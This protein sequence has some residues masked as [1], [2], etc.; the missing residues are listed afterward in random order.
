MRLLDVIKN[1]LAITQ[2]SRIR[3][4]PG[5][6]KTAV[7]IHY[8]GGKKSAIA[9]G[10]TGDPLA[11]RGLRDVNT[12]EP[13]VTLNEWSATPDQ[14][15]LCDSDGLKSQIDDLAKSKILGCLNTESLGRGWVITTHAG[16]QTERDNW[17]RANT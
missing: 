7:I 14:E 15:L 12:P 9:D 4:L 3:L 1:D 16:T 8:I 17:L 13:P 10:L 6:G 11:R 5:P 2:I